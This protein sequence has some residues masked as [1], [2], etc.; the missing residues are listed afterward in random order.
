MNV[1]IHR[2][3]HLLF[4]VWDRRMDFLQ[5]HPDLGADA[6][7]QSGTEDTSTEVVEPVVRIAE[8]AG[9]VLGHVL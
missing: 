5:L 1:P 2:E 9:E 4:V 8:H 3:L 7:S 6:P